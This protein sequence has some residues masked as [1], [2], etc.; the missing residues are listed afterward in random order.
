MHG[1]NQIKNER[2]AEVSASKY[3]QGI[4]VLSLQGIQSRFILLADENTDFGVNIGYL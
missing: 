3:C 4:I 1:E 2:M